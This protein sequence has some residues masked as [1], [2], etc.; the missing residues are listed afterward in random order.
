MRLVYSLLLFLHLAGVIVWVGGMFVVH[1]AVRPAVAAVLEPPQ[2]LALMAQVLTRF[3]LWVT[4]A[5]AVILASGIALILGAGG[6]RNAHL[7]VHLMF[8]LGLVMMAIFAH[9]RTA[10][11]RRLRSA[12]AAA[13]WP[14]AARELQSVRSLVTL[15]LV[16][17][18]VNVG[19]ATIGRALL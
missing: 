7:S 8:G 1:V 18:V 11:F 10:P 14:A 3:F 6:F 2:R 15:N 12:V 9:I 16:L 13:D 19:V 5:I 17:G 4:I